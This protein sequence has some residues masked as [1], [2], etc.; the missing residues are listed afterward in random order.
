MLEPGPLRRRRNARPPMSPVPSSSLLILFSSPT[1]HCFFFFAMK[2]FAIFAAAALAGSV[3]ANPLAFLTKRSPKIQEQ[4]ILTSARPSVDEAAVQVRNLIKSE[5]FADMNTVFQSGPLEGSAIGLLE[6][7]ADCSEDG[8]LT[9]LMVEVGHNYK[10]WLEGSP[11]SFSIK[12]T[13]KFFSLSPA[14]EPRASLTGNL[15]FIE[16]DEEIKKAEFCFLHRHPDAKAW[17]PGNKIHKTAFMTFVPESVYW[18][19]GFGNVAYIGDIP[20][21]MYKNVTLKAPLPF[22]HFPPRHGG[23]DDHDDDAPH[24]KRPPMPAFSEIRVPF[25]DFSVGDRE[26]VFWRPCRSVH[27]GY[28]EEDMDHFHPRPHMHH[29]YD[30]EDMEH[31]RPGRPMHHGYDEED[32]EH[33]RP[34][35]PMH[36]GYDEEDMDHFRPRRPMHHGF[37]E[38]GFKL[39]LKGNEFYKACIADAFHLAATLDEVDPATLSAI[40][41]DKVLL[42]QRK[43]IRRPDLA[44]KTHRTAPERMTGPSDESSVYDYVRKMLFN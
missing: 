6:Y 12:Y 32:M 11:V 21:E 20:I 31:F 40:V 38:E 19:G 25:V 27:H 1:N 2:L 4:E 10:N 33:F 7:Y 29:G 34:R 5:A 3:A 43:N 22:P 17:L 16:D 35:R 36:H 30:E 23:D 39:H 41:H 8:T 26:H 14:S 24:E 28:D 9:L 18:L 42:C 37:D 15:S 13:P 44:R